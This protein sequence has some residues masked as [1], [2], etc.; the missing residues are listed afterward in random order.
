MR[1]GFQWDLARQVERLDWLLAQLPR[2][3]EWGYQE[4]YLH[5]ED[6]VDYPSLP[7]IARSDAYSWAQFERLVQAAGRAGIGVVPIV[8]LLGHTQY[9]LRSPRWRDLNELRAPDGSPLAQGQICPLHPRTAEAA[10]RLL[11]DVAPFCTTGKVHVGL[12]ESYHLGKH[13]LS[14][15][16]IAQVGLEG[17]FARYVGRLRGIAAGH[18]LRLGL[19]ADML[20][21]LPQA[22]PLLPPDVVAYDWYYYPFARSPRIE[23]RNF[24]EYDL[25]PALR[26]RGIEYWGCP[27]SGA[28]RHEPLPIAGERLANIAAWWK[29]CQA[30]EAAGMLVTSW[31][32]QRL[33]AEIPQAIAAA[34]AGLWLE[35]ERR[36]PQLLRSG[37]R[38]AFGRRGPRAA[39]ALA[40]ADRH[41]FLGYARWQVNERWDTSLAPR[42]AA[43]AEAEARACRAL[44]GSPGL[45]PA[46]DA[47]LRF[48]AYLAER[49]RFVRSAGHAV[50]EIRRQ[51]AAERPDAARELIAGQERA[52][53]AFVRALAAGLAAARAMARR[54]RPAR[55]R[56]DNERVLVADAA[57]LGAWQA[58]LGRARRDSTHA[59]TAS[60]VAGKFQLIVRLRN[61]APAAQKVAVQQQDRTG[62][63][64]DAHGCFLIEFRARAARPD[65]DLGHD[66]SAPIDWDGPPF[67]PRPLRLAVRGFGQVA[68]ERARLSDGVR[69]WRAELP[70]G[71]VIGR[72]APARGY[73]RFDWQKDRGA[74]ALSRWIESK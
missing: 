20:A 68:V 19:W 72:P 48:R 25:A 6:A 37:C 61:F 29:R 40:A 45:P 11:R 49:D 50:W 66:L 38:R 54:S 60:P 33:A 27:M 4:L 21:L 1:R 42:L 67:G 63:W 55:A 36:I 17:H 12:D 52:A 71:A 70:E 5:L 51:F 16:E 2:Y 28:F 46:L 59:F 56:G 22:I 30:V 41:P 18:R 14:R 24:A 31:E 39:A 10:E 26:R 8:N 43:A 73:P 34:A 44:A 3:A 9:L 15:A 47:S 7:G 57:R 62:A 74:L 64:Q 65:A 58:W 53:A 35:D 32:P 13:P 23:L 69:A